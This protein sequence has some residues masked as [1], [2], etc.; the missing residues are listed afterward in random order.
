MSGEKKSCVFLRN[1]T[2]IKIL[3]P[4]KNSTR[5]NQ[6]RHLH[7][8]D[9]VYKPKPIC[10]D[11]DVKDK[12]EM[13]FFNGGSVIMDYIDISARSNNLKLMMDLFLTNTQLLASLD[14]NWWTVDY[15]D[16]FIRLSFW[17]HP[18]TA[19]TLM[20]CYISPNLIHSSISLMAWGWVHFKYNIFKCIHLVLHLQHNI[21]LGKL[22]GNVNITHY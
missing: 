7:R 6:E 9:T 18:F 15:C 19:E 16:V 12:Q 13:N 4:V 8:P 22:Y 14:V 21:F 5:L 2:S 1:K 17:R 11:L 10:V 20:Q 3:S